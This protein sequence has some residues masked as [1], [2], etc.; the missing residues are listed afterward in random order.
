MIERPTTTGS[1]MRFPGVAG[2]TIWLLAVAARFDSVRG[3]SSVAM[4]DR[5]ERGLGDSV[6]IG[7]GVLVGFAV[8]VGVALGSGTGVAVSSGA[9]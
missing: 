6:K 2:S 8:F 3:L 1:E 4:R 9:W 5:Y 7:V